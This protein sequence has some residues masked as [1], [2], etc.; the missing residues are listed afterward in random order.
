MDS[1]IATINSTLQS[2]H[3]QCDYLAKVEL[4][5]PRPNFKTP[6]KSIKLLNHHIKAGPILTEIATIREVIKKAYR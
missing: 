3:A 1:S 4:W 5:K 6:T 2:I